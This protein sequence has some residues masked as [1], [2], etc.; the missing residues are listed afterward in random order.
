MTNVRDFGAV[1]DGQVDDT[2]AL[3][4]AVDQGGGR[5]VL[6]RG[7]YRLTA[8]LEI[9]LDRFG[10]IALAGEGGTAR[11]LMDGP[12]PAVRLVGSHDKSADPASFD[13]RVWRRQRLP[14]VSDLE[15]VGN[16]DQ[17]DGI[18]L[19]GT[20]QATIA[21]VS[22]RRCRYGV[23][24]V[25]RNRNVLLADSHIYEGRGPAIG[26]YFDGVNLHQAIITGCHISFCKHAGIKIVR[27]E[28]RNLQ[29]TGCDIEYNHDIA[30]PDS[31]DVW[32]DSRE[33]TVREGTLASNTIQA[34]GSPRGANVRIEGPSRDDSAGAG[35]WAITGNILS[36]Q[37]VNVW[38]R[39]CRGVTLTGNAIASAY[40]RSI[41]V[42]HCRD[43]VIGSNV[44]DHN[45][46]YPGAI[47]DGI[48][49]VR[50]AGVN[51]QNLILDGCR[52]GSPQEG[53]AIE[54]VDSSEVLILGCQ[55]LDPEHRGI[56]V[57]NCTNTKVSECIV[58]DRRARPTMREPIRIV[59]RTGQPGPI[60]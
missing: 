25:K 32:I 42:E 2:K 41:L 29:I 28:I 53:G 11:L 50:S 34:K 4:H 60:A 35:F 9:D 20:M 46:D 12:G 58:V 15:I 54:V 21:G 44:L 56:D 17:A 51:L 40:E 36:D 5:L 49:V 47:I 30:N 1:G 19:E 55:V 48:R 18:E 59:E 39:N 31:A 13:P 10:P 26:V 7:T 22:I 45:P 23:H 38:L 16:H 3:R 27:S 14:T 33:G 24:L 43:I 52:A 6:S 37:Q 8:P 57:R